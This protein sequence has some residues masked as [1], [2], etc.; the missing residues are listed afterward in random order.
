MGNKPL[1]KS[2]INLFLSE[3][4]R[5]IRDQLAQERVTHKRN[6]PRMKQREILLLEELLTNLSPKNCLEWGSGYSTLYYPHFIDRAGQWLAIEHHSEWAK[7]VIDLNPD[8]RVR[9]AA[10][11]PQHYPWTDQHNDGAYND[12]PEYVDYPAQSAPYDFILV[13][14]RA[15]SECLAKAYEWISDRGIVVLH[16]AMRPYYHPA[17]EV[18]PQQ[19]FFTLKGRSDHRGL[20]LGSKGKPLGEYLNLARHQK[21]W[22][23]HNR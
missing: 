18:F 9:V 4:Y 22:A 21:L 17:L 14:G 8:E 15:R 3:Q 13:D 20:W 1:G 10:I 7:L 11:A 6:V 2:L 19:I 12:L 23:W 16:D 5:M